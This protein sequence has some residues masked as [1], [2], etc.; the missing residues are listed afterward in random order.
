MEEEET[1][2]RSEDGES[3]D[4]FV[5][6]EGSGESSAPWITAVERETGSGDYWADNLQ[7]EGIECSKDPA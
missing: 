2:K 6:D 7:Q 1:P 4:M 3:L 5:G